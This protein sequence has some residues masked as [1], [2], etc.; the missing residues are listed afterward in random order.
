MLKAEDYKEPSCTLCG[1]KEFY[2]PKKDDALGRIPVSRILEK[3]DVHFNRNDY[4]EAGRLLEYWL[5]EAISLNDKRGELSILSELIG[6]YRKQGDKDKALSV[7]ERATALISD[8]E[9][10]DGVSG[11]TIILNAATAY[12]A[13][14]LAEKAMPLFRKVEEIYKAN[15]DSAD[16]RF[17]GLYNNMALALVDLEKFTDAENAYLLALNVMQ[18]AENGEL[19]AAITY[20]NMA[21]LYEQFNGDRNK[22]TDCLF[23]AYNL[24]NDEKIARNGY[25]AFVAE[26]CAPSFKYFGFNK[27]YDQLKKVSDE[28]YKR[29]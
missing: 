8:L 11:A 17:G 28:I 16:V 27:I 26:K 6:F 29:N 14:G 7:I 1:G 12:K 20:V 5:N 18:K 22:I 25:Y 23:T 10:D 24:L 21:H 13:F 2:N 19:D 15:L 3:V 4:L 9:Q